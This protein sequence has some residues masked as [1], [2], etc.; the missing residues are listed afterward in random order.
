MEGVQPSRRA[1]AAAAGSSLSGLLLGATGALLGAAAFL[2]GAS[3]DARVPW[4]GGG[5]VA[6]AAAL[7][8]A[9][10]LGIAPLPALERPAALAVAS[11]LA[12]A[13]WTGVTIVWSVAGDQTWS[14]LNKGIAYAGFLVV[15]LG[16]ASFGTSTTRRAA[17]LLALVLALVLAWAVAGKAVPALAPDDAVRAPR[18]H[19]PVG[20]A[21]ALALLADAALVLGLWA[22]AGARRSSRTAGLLLAYL[23]VVAGLLTSSRAGAVAGVLVLATWL[24]LAPRR[25][26]GAVAAVAACVPAAVVAGWA[27]TRPA[28]VDPGQTRADRARDGAVLAA[29]V[30]AGA[31]VALGAAEA[32]RRLLPGRERVAARA[33]VL[34][35][36]LALVAG[37]SATAVAVGNPVT[38][39]TDAFSQGECVNT[40]GRLGKLCA[41]NRLQ[42]WRE[43]ARIFAAHPAG[44]TGAGTFDVARTRY[45][46]AGDD[47]KEPHSVPLQVLAGTG[48]PGGALLALL[49]VATAVA[50]RRALRTLRDEERAAALALLALPLAYAVHALV[51][52]DVDFLAVT[53]PALFAT[54]VLLGAGRPPVRVRAGPLPALHALAVVS[55]AATAVGSLV[56]PRLAADLADEANAAAEAGR[57]SLA[58]QRARDARSLDPLSPEPLY[59]LAAAYETA[60]AQRTGSA[61]DEALLSAR[62]A[63]A[64]A[65]RLQPGNAATWYRLGLFEF[66]WTRDLCAA[67]QALN[68]SYTLDPRSTH[69]TKGGELDQARDAVDEGACERS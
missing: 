66:L 22:A 31:V 48:V 57:V 13:A 64:A 3:G 36:A 42:W 39:A 23:A 62:E 9:F 53:G 43:A 45:R 68:H 18:L 65:T 27:F 15:G 17:G 41:N 21:N 61:R 19:A 30:V 25:V 7:L 28:L 60:A 46:K 16:F 35:A 55:V 40:P 20:Y 69:W 26:E 67:Y 1:V 49:A 33:L 8:A 63:Y 6:L 24:A 47:V 11:L 59:A 4:I 58:V 29:L 44:G 34:A 51:D 12:L 32:G 37:V 56:L 52:Y 10:A 38:R 50:I 14:A 54:G 2:G 5:A